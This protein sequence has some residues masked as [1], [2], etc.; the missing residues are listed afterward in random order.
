VGA[1]SGASGGKNFFASSKYK[2]LVSSSFDQNSYRIS[3]SSPASEST[4]STV[5]A[6]ALSEGLGWNLI[7]D[8]TGSMKAD[9]DKNRQITLHE[10]WLYTMKQCMNYLK[11]STARQTVQVW[12][13]GDQFVIVK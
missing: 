5:F 13:R 4:M 2:V 3:S 8:K 11:N 7:K 9:I 10:A 1:F 6:R 12:P